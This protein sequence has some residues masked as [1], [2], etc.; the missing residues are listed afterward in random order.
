MEEEEEG[1]D[2]PSSYTLLTNSSRAHPPRK[3]RHLST[4]LPLKSY[5]P[6]TLARV[7]DA[8]LPPRTSLA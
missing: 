3:R 7:L 5:D 4:P 2:A 1:E 8:E 6:E